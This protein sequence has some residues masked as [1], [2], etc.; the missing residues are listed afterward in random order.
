MA[1]W[2][3]RLV[4]SSDTERWLDGQGPPSSR[5]QFPVLAETLDHLIRNQRLVDPTLS[6]PEQGLNYGTSARAGSPN[7]N[8][9]GDHIRCRSMLI[10]LDRNTRFLQLST[11]DGTKPCVRGER[12]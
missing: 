5:T 6:I 1:G 7:G 9:D 3:R 12:S 2:C 10:T 8:A 11:P 4:R